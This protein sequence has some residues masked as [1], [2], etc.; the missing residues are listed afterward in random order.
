MSRTLCL[1]VAIVGVIWS[2]ELFGDRIKG[3]VGN[4]GNNTPSDVRV[5]QT[6]LNSVPMTS[7]GPKKPLAIDGSIG[8]KTIS[9]IERFQHLQLGFKD[10]L[11]EPGKT[12]ES[13]L[14]EFKDFASQ[15]RPDP[16][17]CW[18]NRVTGSFKTE[19]LRIAKTLKIDANYLMAAMAFESAE[20]FSPAIKN[21][22]GS[23]ATGLIQFMP[24]TAKGLG[25]TTDKLAKMTAVKQLSYVE[26]YFKRFRGKCKTLSDVYMAI[27]WPAAVGKPESHVLFEKGKDGKRYTQNA[28][29]DAD[30][31]GK[32]TKKEAATKVH[33]KLKRGNAD[34]FKG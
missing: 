30:K 13:R 22:A 34:G 24:S 5:V 2:A 6:L 12:T 20:S 17:I 31:D 25:T 19:V 33:K 23:G 29:L 8:P 18:G 7:G 28:G 14:L 32:I 3:S 15:L 4:G 1:V 10:G 27:L 21:A 26:K 11:I 16:K 9:S